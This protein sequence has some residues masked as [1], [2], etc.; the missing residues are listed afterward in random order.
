MGLWPRKGQIAEGSDADI[1]VFDPNK[2]WTVRWQDLHMSTEYNCWDGWEL[3]GK[4]RDTIL[5]GSV[6]VDNEE[7]IGDKGGGRFI[8]RTLLPEVVS[9]NFAFTAQAVGEALTTV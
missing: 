6:I 4:V 3:T 7:W 8:P 2:S 5:R 9:G 1:V